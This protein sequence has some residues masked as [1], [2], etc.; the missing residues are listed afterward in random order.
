[1][2]IREALESGASSVEKWDTRNLNAQ[3]EETVNQ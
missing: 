1:M 2:M 3:M